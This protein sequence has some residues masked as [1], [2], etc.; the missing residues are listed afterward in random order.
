MDA[1]PP[2]DIDLPI[3]TVK[4]YVTVPLDPCKYLQ[5]NKNKKY[6]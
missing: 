1:I 3:H 5:N 4:G 6:F 2:T